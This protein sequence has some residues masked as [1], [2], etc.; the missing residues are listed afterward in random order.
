MIFIIMY[1]YEV[2]LFNSKKYNIQIY[3]DF[4]FISMNSNLRTNT[5]QF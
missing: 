2:L 1:F 5:N 4:L 3:E